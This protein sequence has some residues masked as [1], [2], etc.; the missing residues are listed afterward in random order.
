MVHVLQNFLLQLKLYSA[1][2]SPIPY[3]FRY[4]LCLHVPYDVRHT[5]PYDVRHPGTLER[6]SNNSVGHVL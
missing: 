3:P 1:D 5:G 4:D 6:N 2:L